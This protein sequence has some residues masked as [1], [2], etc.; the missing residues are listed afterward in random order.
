MT[1]G[2]DNFA[3]YNFDDFTIKNYKKMLQMMI[4]NGYAFEFYKDEYLFSKPIVLLRHDVEFSPFVVLEMA[5]IENDLGIKST[6]FFQI[7]SD[8]YNFLEREISDIA[9]EISNLGHNIG[10]HFDSH[11]YNIKNEKE[12]CQK[13]IFDSKIIEAEIGRHIEVFSFHNT[14]DQ[15]LGYKKK[16]YAGLLNVYSR[17]F[18]DKFEYHSDSTGIWRY[19]RLFDVLNATEKKSMQILIHDAMWSDIVM[20]PKER[21]YSTIDKNAERVKRHYDETLEMYGAKNIDWE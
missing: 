16:R 20:S 7:H 13:I 6:Y 10:L 4:N 5:R 19:E 3:I 15:V 18:M 1:T 12:L 21:I 9:L 17:Y 14:D 11:Y 2:S 8:F